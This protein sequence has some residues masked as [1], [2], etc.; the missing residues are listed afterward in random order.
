M[1]IVAL[2]D[3]IDNLYAIWNTV[4]DRFLGVNLPRIEAMDIIIRYKHCS[5]A[6]ANS[7]LD[8][9]E[10]FCNITE[11]IINGHKEGVYVK[12][13]HCEEVRK[14]ESGEIEKLLKTHKQVV[15]DCLCG[16]MYTVEIDDG[17]IT[18]HLRACVTN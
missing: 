3:D 10:P 12:C 4:T 7:R 8:H 16:E 2:Q 9:P 18:T 1:L 13:P 11:H 5:I 14:L 17:A 15:S 6:E